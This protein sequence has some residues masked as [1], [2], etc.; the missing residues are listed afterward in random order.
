MGNYI[1][2]TGNRYGK[3]VVLEEAGRDDYRYV[4][5]KC[6]CDCGN[7]TH[8]RAGHL[9]SGNT[10]SCGCTRRID[11]TGNRY[12]KLVVLEWAGTGQ[13]RYAMWKCECDC[14]NV[15]VVRGNNLRTG[16]TRSCGCGR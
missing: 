14:G 8:V 16:N 10:T 15:T 2:E 5:W 4:V 3:L 12:G 11:E 7:T 13:N 1:D 6:A 9:R